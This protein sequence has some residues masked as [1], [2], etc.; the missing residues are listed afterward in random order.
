MALWCLKLIVA[1]SKSSILFDLTFDVLIWM[2]SINNVWCIRDTFFEILQVIGLIQRGWQTLGYK[3]SFQYIRPFYIE[4]FTV[5]FILCRVGQKEN[6][7]TTCFWSINR[8]KI[9]SYVINSLAFTTIIIG[10]CLIKLISSRKIN[11]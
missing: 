3:C 6:W 7:W 1:D 10:V 8:R 11:C 5:N 4:I 9:R 2:N